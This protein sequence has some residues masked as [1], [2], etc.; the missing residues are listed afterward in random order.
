MGYW[1][2]L[3]PTWDNF[4]EFYHWLWLVPH[5]DRVRSRTR[6]SHWFYLRILLYGP[7]PFLP[8]DRGRR[9]HARLRLPAKEFDSGKVTGCS[10]KRSWHSQSLKSVHTHAMTGEPSRRMLKKF[11]H[12]P[13][14]PRR[15][16]TPLWAH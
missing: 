10:E 8:N 6:C 11:R 9:L 1:E 4:L 13:T 3:S 16:K 7:A 15:A 2:N 14:Q 5:V 12:P